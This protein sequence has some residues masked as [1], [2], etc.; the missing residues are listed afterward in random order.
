M[1][2][3]QA[4]MGVVVVALG[5]FYYWHDVVGKP[6]REE[7]ETKQKR[8][9]PDVKRA[10]LTG[11][12]VERLKEL[13]TNKPYKRVISKKH[14]LWV[15]EEEKDLEVLNTLSM[16]AT[17]KGIVEVQRALKMTESP[18]DQLKPSEFGLEKPSYRL[19]LKCKD[20]KSHTLLIG[21]KMPDGNGYYVQ[22]DNGPI[23]AVG[24]TWPDLLEGPT[25]KMRETSA[26]P[27]EL[28]KISR[29]NFTLP[30]GKKVETTLAKPREKEKGK[31]ELDDGIEITD[32]NEEWKQTSPVAAV[33][34]PRKI[35]D[36][37]QL[38]KGAKH[39]RFL[40]PQEKID[41]SKPA[42]RIEATVDGE[43]EPY[44]MEVGPVVPNQPNMRYLRRL[45]PDETMVVEM[46]NPKLMDVGVESFEQRHLAAFEGDDVKKVE[47][48]IK[49][50]DVVASRSDQ[51]W[52]VSKPSKPVGDQNNWNNAINDLVFEI[53]S[54]EWK[55]KSSGTL[56]PV[57]KFDLLDKDGKKLLS[58]S[59]GQE[60]GKGRLAQVEGSK[61]IVVLEPDPLSKWESISKRL[62]VAAASPTPGASGTPVSGL[63]P[64]LEIP[65]A[66]TTPVVPLQ[67]S[68][69]PAASP[70]PT[71]TPK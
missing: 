51:D 55:S 10:D 21:D 31:E 45:N 62:L 15:L 33:A 38:W 9:F 56:S 5:G 46:N 66:G 29:V 17:T 3:G 7:A 13:G 12:T 19:E 27:Y 52:S 59:L 43:T 53:K 67:K 50:L 61:D 8:L 63:P 69:Q 35:R 49:D 6:K 70:A 48:K 23:E 32:L 40:H 2:R 36:F 60:S 18:G 22:A 1:N 28:S 20:G 26:V 30:D 64:A 65:T 57:G 11:L 34:D 24:A 37:L 41:F 58:F 25:D 42:L 54:T 71:S 4:F 68:P 39:N 16:G 44:V 47:I 14:G